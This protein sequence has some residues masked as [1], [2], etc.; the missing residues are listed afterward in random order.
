MSDLATRA[1]QEI[2]ALRGKVQL[3]GFRP[4]KVPTAHL[5]RVYGRSVM[6]DV[7]QNAVN[8]ANRRLVEE[9]AFKLALEPQIA[10]TE[11][12]GEIARVMNGEADLSYRVT[13]EVLP[14][15]EVGDFSGISVERLTA[16]VPDEDVQAELGRLARQNRTF[17]PKE[18]DGVAAVNGDRVTV[19][20]LGQ[21]DGAPFEGG[22]GEDIKVELG[23]DSFIP[24]FEEG[25]VG[26]GIGEARGETHGR[27]PRRGPRSGSNR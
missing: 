17:T 26:A 1:D 11:D 27:Q 5:K 10:F 18:G 9:R 13:L 3:K 22:K 15:F 21:V 2:E 7:V 14:T 6:A 24:G 16:Q 23:S 4:G 12:Q 25:L 8:D 20:F 19:D